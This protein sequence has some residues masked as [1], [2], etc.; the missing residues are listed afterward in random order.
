M[1]QGKGYMRKGDMEINVPKRKKKKSKVPMKQ[2]IITIAVNL[3]E[4][5]DKALELAAQ[6]NLEEYQKQEKEQRNKA[7]H[8]T[9]VLENDVNKQVDE[10][11]VAQM[12]LKLKAQKQVSPEEQLL[13]NL[14]QGANE[15]KK[16]RI[17]EEIIKAPGEGAC[18]VPGSPYHSDSSDNSI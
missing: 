14:K 13:L 17:L 2:R 11:C 8:A 16:Q 10:A 18:A 1:G 15:S 12:K 3:L 7:R 5:L 6:I 4:D 9:L